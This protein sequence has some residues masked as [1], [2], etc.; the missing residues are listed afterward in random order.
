MDHGFGAHLHPVHA[1]RL[2]VGE[3]FS[4][5]HCAIAIR[6]HFGKPRRF[7]RIDLGQ[8]QFAIAIAVHGGKIKLRP[9]RHEALS[10]FHF[11]IAAHPAH[12]IGIVRTTS[13]KRRDG[14]TQHGK[15]SE[16]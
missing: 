3:Q 14:P 13:G 8:G 7:E 1:L 15:Q 11:H 9:K 12:L 4:R 10:A 6:I 16:S 5:I 2:L